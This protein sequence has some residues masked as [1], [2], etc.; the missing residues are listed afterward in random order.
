VK[1]GRGDVAAVMSILWVIQTTE[2]QSSG[3][4]AGKKPMKEE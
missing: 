1:N 4:S 2:M 3:L